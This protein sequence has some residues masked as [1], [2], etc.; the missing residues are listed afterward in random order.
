MAQFKGFK[1]IRAHTPELQN[2][3]RE[4]LRYIRELEGRLGTL[5]AAEPIGI[6][7]ASNV[8][9]RVLLVKHGSNHAPYGPDETKW[10]HRSTIDPRPLAVPQY[11]LLYMWD[12]QAEG[13]DDR[14]FISIQLADASWD[15]AGLF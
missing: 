5:I 12:R 4:F 11:P 6:A 10:I 15:W 2:D 14:L 9:T 1:N 7:A 8:R 13:K 3:L